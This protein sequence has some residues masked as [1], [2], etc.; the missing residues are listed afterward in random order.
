MKLVNHASLGTI[1]FSNNGVLDSLTGS[2]APKIFLNNLARE[3]SKSRRKY[4]GI[5]IIT[6]KLRFDKRKLK[7]RKPPNNHHVAT[8][9]TIAESRKVKEVIDFEKDL[10]KI[11]RLIKSNMRGGDFYSRIP[12]NGFWIC[13]QGDEIEAE[14][15]AE[16]LRLKMNESSS[17]LI[18]PE[19][20]EYSNHEWNNSLDVE[21]FIHAVDLAY[22]N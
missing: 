12:E 3:I 5:S 15:A 19:R 4:Q 18:N 1:E 17:R 16:R 10:V 22:F 13:L 9:N 6:L 8:N 11:S 21:D 2:P 14:K 20:I 7:S